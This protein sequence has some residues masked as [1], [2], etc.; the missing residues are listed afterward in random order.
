M[1]R[2]TDQIV[3]KALPP[4]RGQA[5]FWD[6]EIKGF[7]L[8]VTPGGAKSFILDYRADGR[9]RRITIGASPDWTVAAAREAAKKL[10]REVDNGSDP[11]GDRHDERNAATMAELWEKYEREHL[12]QKSDRSQADEK[13]MWKNII[14]PRF[15]KMKLTS[16][17]ASEI[18]S[19]H[20]DITNIRKTPVRANRVIEVLRKAFNLAIRWKWL[21]ENPVTGVRRNPE[22]K[23]DRYLNKQEISA[24]VTALNEHK[25]QDSANAIKLLMLTGARKS[26]VLGATWE[27]FDLENGIWTKPSSHTKQR[28]LHRVPLSPPALRLLK[29]IKEE[30]SS[31]YIFPGTDKK[32][33]QD[34]KRTWVTVCKK[35]G[36]VESVP[37]K[38]RKGKVVKDKNG[39]DVMELVPNVRLHDLR[40]SFASILVS[41]GASL[42]LI[43]QMLGHT[44][45]STTQRYAHLY[46]AP[47]RKAAEMVSDAIPVQFAN[48]KR[49]KV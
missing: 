34:V 13:S 26:E 16:I 39:E 33:L 10:K 38:D 8:R 23:R 49:K 27:M 28:K 44:Q 30:S 46:D 14:L 42:P 45:V 37:K 2:L 21:K 20:R 12:G 43:G 41:G 24:L 5:M 29:E 47:L 19:L 4:V 7:G 36:L 3:K 18:D 25:E 11:M 15:G 40:H 6:D 17:T 31:V 9:Q 22:E 35:A 1:T 48:K 32:P